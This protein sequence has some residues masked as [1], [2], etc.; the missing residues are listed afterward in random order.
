MPKGHALSEATKDAIWELRAK[1]LERSRDRAPGW[2]ATRQRQP[3]LGEDGRHPAEAPPACRALPEPRRARGDLAS[4]RPR[5]LGPRD[6]P[7]P[8]PLAHDDRA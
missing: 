4:D 2:P 6:R 3:P 7:D 1:G 5:A 8:G